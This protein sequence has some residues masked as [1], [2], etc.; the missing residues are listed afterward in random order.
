MVQWV[1]V[2]TQQVS[3]DARGC[4]CLQH[5]LSWKGRLSVKQLPDV[6][7]RAADSPGEGR[8]P[9]CQSHSRF[10]G[11]ERGDRCVHEENDNSELVCLQ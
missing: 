8:L 5:E 1:N 6:A 9:L 4:L 3:R 2:R 10:E 7:L 11:G